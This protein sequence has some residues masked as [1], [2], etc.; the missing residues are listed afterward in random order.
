MPLPV[1]TDDRTRR[2]VDTIFDRFFQNSR[3]PTFEELDRHL[4]RRGDP[5][6][7][8]ALKAAPAG[9]LY[10]I[11]PSNAPPQDDQAVALTLAGLMSCEAALED[12]SAFVSAVGLACDISDAAPPGVGDIVLT[13]VDVR[14]RLLV[15]GGADALLRRLYYILSV[16]RWGTKGS[17][18]D[19]S[20]G[21][22]SFTIHPRELRRLRG[23]KTAAE[24]WRRLHAEDEPMFGTAATLRSMEAG[25]SRNVWVVHGRDMQQRDAMF[26]FLRSLSLNPMEFGDVAIQTG[27]GAPYVGQILETAFKQ[28]KA[29][30][31]LLSPDEVAYLRPELAEHDGETAPGRQ[32]RPNVLFEAGMAFGHHPDRTILVEVGDLRPFSDIAGRHAIRL[33][34]QLAPLNELAG[35][36]EAAGCPVNRNGTDW[37]R[38]DRFP[39]P[40][41]RSLP[42]GRKVPSKP[43]G[44][45]HLGVKLAFYPSGKSGRLHVRNIGGETLYDVVLELPPEIEMFHLLQDGPIPKIPAG[46]TVRLPAFAV[47][48][49]GGN[50]PSSFDVSV[51]ARTAGGAEFREDVF[52]DIGG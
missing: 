50:G 40:P 39:D 28:A 43:S 11:G 47:K 52:L 41:A 10:G 31:V 48:T 20:T 44:G 15:A 1:V 16:E 3:W 6:A 49:F 5:D 21:A 37:T 18:R 35:R 38:L 29:V 46:E 14:K 12:V 22:W 26:D 34:G 2:L 36:L 7:L 13:S 23:A 33:N 8:S 51:V 27:V 45:P 9:L 17:H 4:D 25:T 19:T 30:V 42:L 32:A 24:C